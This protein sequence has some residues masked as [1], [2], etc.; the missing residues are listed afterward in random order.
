MR[1]QY[2][3]C[4]AGATALRTALDKRIA[5]DTKEI[6]DLNTKLAAAEQASQERDAK[7][8]KLTTDAHNV[9]AQLDETTA[10]NSQL[11]DEITHLGG[12]VNKILAEKGDL[13]KSLAD[14]KA[15]L[16]ELTKAQQ[17]ADARAKLFRDFIAKFKKMID[18]GQLKVVVRAG[19]L[20]IQLPND[21]LFDSGQTDIKPA[22]QD[23]LKQIA[24]TFVG[25]TDRKFQVAGNTDNVPITTSR[26]PSNWE[27]S[28]ARAVQVV[29]LLILQ[30]VPAGM[31]SA[32]GYGEFDPIAPNDTPDN[33]AKN[34]RIEIALQPNIQDL[35]AVPDLN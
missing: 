7:I 30:G 32:A 33:Q 27:L 1:G 16:D 14:A 24:K 2:D 25:I 12:D 15:R 8:S 19:R 10:L 3:E 11:R 13:A 23:A 22:G 17:A 5:D 26:F 20:V 4:I 34:R 29:K 6:A 21:V 35:V 31:L 28:T 18:A 9:Q